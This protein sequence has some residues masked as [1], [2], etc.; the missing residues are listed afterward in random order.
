MIRAKRGFFAV[1]GHF[2]SALS[3]V[4]PSVRIHSNFD[5]ARQWPFYPVPFVATGMLAIFSEA[6][7]TVESLPRPLMVALATTTVLLLALSAVFRSR[8]VGAYATLCIALTILD[9]P[10]V[11]VLMAAI[12]ASA[13]LASWIFR[14]ARSGIP[15][16]RVTEFFNTAGLVL[17]ALSIGTTWSSGALASATP[18]GPGALTHGARMGPDIYVILLD[19]HPRGDTMNEDFGL[20]SGTFLGELERLGFE[21]ADQSHSNYN[22]TSLT[23]AS[24]FNMVQVQSIDG[25]DARQPPATQSRAL[26]R[27]INHGS[28][29]EQLRGV[30]YEIVTVPSP[31]GI[32]TLRSAD[33]IVDDGAITQFEFE[34]LQV[35]ITPLL[36]PDLQRRLVMGS[37]RSRVLAS[38]EQTVDLA[39]ERTGRPKLVF[40]HVMSPHAPVLFSADGTPVDGWPCYPKCSAFDFGW[41]YGDEALAPI[42]GQIQY[43]DTKVIET[44]EQIL[45]ASPEPPIIILFSDHGSRHRVDDREEMLRSL[46]VSFT[47]GKTG[48]FPEDATPVN[49]FPR[50]LNEYFGTGVPLSSEESYTTDLSELQTK[51]P[52]NL[53]RTPTD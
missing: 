52:L 36:L 40:T 23:L 2:C 20:D 48:V 4:R 13:A 21:V 51:G 34:A 26:A 43:V 17:L 37:L 27:A 16:P 25:L 11:G 12:P 39:Q 53:E 14:R 28:V 35:G 42:A 30:G 47:P 49:L 8:H 10:I 31:A 1:P 22:F 44:V 38:L 7:A 5:R 9:W 45:Q 50:L 41:R 32:V 19:G 15:W 18:T 6:T 46:L 33:R 24:M 3:T 29:F